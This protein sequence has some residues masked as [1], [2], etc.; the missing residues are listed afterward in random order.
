M[1]IYYDFSLLLSVDHNQPTDS[2]QFDFHS[3]V[4]YFDMIELNVF[5]QGKINVCM[6]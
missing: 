2:N 5:V 6:F 3:L 1:I 4:Y